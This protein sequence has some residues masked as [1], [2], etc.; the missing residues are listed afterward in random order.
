MDEIA[1]WSSATATQRRKIVDA[2]PARLA[3]V[4]AHSELKEV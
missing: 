4:A 1:G 2:L 3:D